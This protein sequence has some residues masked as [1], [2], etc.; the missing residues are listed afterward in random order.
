MY[1]Y[2]NNPFTNLEKQIG[3]FKPHVTDIVI[4]QNITDFK[5]IKECY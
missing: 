1:N 3:I 5:A 2:V 4:N